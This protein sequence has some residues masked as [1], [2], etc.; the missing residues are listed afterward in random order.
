MT[1]PGLNWIVSAPLKM[2]PAFP[3]LKQVTWHSS[4][5]NLVQ[6]RF[7]WYQ[8][9]WGTCTLLYFL[10]T[11][12]IYLLCQNNVPVNCYSTCNSY[13][14]L[15]LTYIKKSNSKDK[16]NKIAVWSASPEKL[17]LAHLPKVLNHLNVAKDKNAACDRGMSLR[18]C[19]FTKILLI[20]L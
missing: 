14:N 6:S 10:N 8:N 7:C 19:T 15:I 17:I 20:M 18:W 2:S 12:N 9:Y 13:T 5:P 3:H 16:M 1:E 4:W 11:R